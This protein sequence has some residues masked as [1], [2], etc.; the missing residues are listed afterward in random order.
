MDAAL[1]DVGARLAR[2]RAIL[3]D[4]AATEL[5]LLALGEMLPNLAE[6]LDAADPVAANR[7]LKDMIEAVVVVG[8]QV[9]EVRLR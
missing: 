4:R 3:A 2:E 8:R 5:R 6:R 9:V 7:W 1:A